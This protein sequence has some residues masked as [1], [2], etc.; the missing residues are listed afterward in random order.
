MAE[1]ADPKRNA[2]KGSVSMNIPRMCPICGMES[3]ESMALD[4]QLSVSLSGQLLPVSHLDAYRCSFGH[5]FIVPMD[6]TVQ[7]AAPYSLF[8]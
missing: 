5:V 3:I 1:K 8:A 4:A 2:S 6:Q 7:E